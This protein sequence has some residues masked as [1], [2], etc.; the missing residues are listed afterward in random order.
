MRAVAAIKRSAGSAWKGSGREYASS[1]TSGVAARGRQPLISMARRNHG[2]LGPVRSMR[3][4]AWAQAISA[5]VMVA[6]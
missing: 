3:P 2:F 5:A 1:I 6:T 4:R